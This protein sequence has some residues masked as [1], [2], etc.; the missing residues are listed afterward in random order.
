M[1]ED[2][3]ILR[4]GSADGAYLLLQ[5]VGHEKLP[6]GMLLEVAIASLQ[7]ALNKAK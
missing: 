7:S 6:F 4:C 3:L 1:R 2:G 5:L